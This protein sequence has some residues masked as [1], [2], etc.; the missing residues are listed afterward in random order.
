MAGG[1]GLLAIISGIIGAVDGG[2]GGAIAAIAIGS[3]FLL[4]GLLPAITAKKTF[5]PRKLIF[6]AQGVRWDDPQGKPWAIAWRELAAVSISKHGALEVKRPSLSE[7]LVEAATDKL[8][9]ENVLVRLDLFPADPGFRARHPEL[10][11]LWQF[12]NVQN[13]YRLSLGR[14]ANY[15]TPMAQALAAFAPNIYK[16]VQTTEGF[17]GLA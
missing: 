15:I 16:G 8:T 10:E 17:M 6:E 13:G 4:I 11:H 5:R 14:S 2:S 12:Q 3:V 1:I 9:G 7:K